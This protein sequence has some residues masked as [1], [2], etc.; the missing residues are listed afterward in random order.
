MNQLKQSLKKV[1]DAATKMT[2]Q[3][4]DVQRVAPMSPV[5][6]P[7]VPREY[8]RVEVQ[9]KL[10]DHLDDLV[11]YWSTEK[12]M[13]GNS[14]PTK[15]ACEGMAFSFLCML[16]GVS[17]LPGFLVVPLGTEEDKEYMREQGENYYTPVSDDIINSVIDVH[18]DD[19]LHEKWRR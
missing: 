5:E 4:Q 7:K 2:R 11:R 6:I 18:G 12:D 8:T 16:D 3:L 14:F 17:D 10:F 9:E 13:E 1:A 15:K 19:M